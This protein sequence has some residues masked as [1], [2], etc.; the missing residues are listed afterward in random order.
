MREEM[1]LNMTVFVTELASPSSVKPTAC[2]ATALDRF[3][4]HAFLVAG[5]S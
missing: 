3:L 2:L 4:V 1:G 5:V